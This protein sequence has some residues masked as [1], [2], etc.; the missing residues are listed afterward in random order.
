MYLLDTHTSM[1]T[2]APAEGSCIP[3]SDFLIQP[4]FSFSYQIAKNR[5]AWEIIIT[6]KS[7]FMT[8]F[9][10]AFEIFLPAPSR[11]PYAPG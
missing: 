2:P 3:W 11:S 5:L 1:V 8:A 6:C 10:H 9:Y 4:L 7:V